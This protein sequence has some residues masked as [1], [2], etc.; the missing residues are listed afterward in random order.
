M[1]K[2]S[3]LTFVAVVAFSGAI[4]SSQSS[5]VTIANR[6]TAPVKVEYTEGAGAQSVEVPAGQE[7]DICE[8][9]CKLTFSGKSIEVKGE[10]SLEI[11]NGALQPVKLK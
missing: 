2:T 6:D 7:V 1:S 4:I 5:A 9:G 8:D 10:E 11:V 3:V